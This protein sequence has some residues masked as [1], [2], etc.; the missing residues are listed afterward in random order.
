MALLTPAG[1]DSAGPASVDYPLL[2]EQLSNLLKSETDFTA[3]AAN[4]SSL[5]YASIPDVNWIGFYRA[6]GSELILG[7]F[8]GRPACSRIAFG[9][10]VCGVVAEK[11]ETLIVPDVNA[12]PGH[13]ACDVASRSEI[14]VPL[15]N[16]GKLLGVLDVDSAS[17]NR[18]TE[19]DLE[20]LE[21][22]ASVFVSSLLTDDLPDLS[23]AAA[24]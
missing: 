19:D 13:I 1:S 17:A 12:F 16:W 11:Q 8:Q 6:E 10:G 9:K 24:T 23:E 5:L 15:L 7:P 20:G 2:C 14:A 18:F 3:N 4:A 22:L 21:S